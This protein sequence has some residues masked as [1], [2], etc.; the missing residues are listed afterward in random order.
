M[1]PYDHDFDVAVATSYNACGE[2]NVFTMSVL[3]S[4]HRRGGGGR[5]GHEHF[6]AQPPLPS[7]NE[8]FLA[9]GDLCNQY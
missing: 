3:P 4:V 7:E 2:C 5:F 9:F 6:L 8:H 1:S